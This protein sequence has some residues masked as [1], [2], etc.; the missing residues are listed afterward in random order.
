MGHIN[1]P[2]KEYHLLQTRFD[3]MVTGAPASPYLTKILE[4]LYS[5]EEANLARKIPTQ[6]TSLKKLVAKTALP[7]E[8]LKDKLTEM[9]ERG[10]LVDFEIKGKKYYTLPPVVIGFFEY[11]FMR[12]RDNLPMAE[13]A[14]L[15]ENYM[16]ENDKFARSVFQKET[17]MGR[18][19]VQEDFLDD[20]TEILDWE[21]ASALI[22]SAPTLGV[23]LCACR[24]KAEH[25]GKNCSAPM[26]V[27]LT[28]GFSAETMIRNKIARQISTEE[29]LD[30][31]KKCREAGLVQTG[32]NVKKHVSFICNCCSCC[33]G[34][35]KS[36]NTFNLKQ[37]IVSSNFIL[38]INKDKCVAC[39]RCVK[40]CPVNALQIETKDDQKKLILN[41]ELCLGCGVC[42]STCKPQ[43]LKMVARPKR[44]FTPETF[45]D[46]TVAMALE[47][48]KLADLITDQK[49][50]LSSLALGRIISLIEKLPPYKA[51]IAIKPLK[52][53][54]LNK[55]VKGIK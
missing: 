50:N 8:K 45:F 20:Q 38:E 29:G 51:L 19:L 34:M 21:K 10:V 7:E 39:G 32:D 33:C 49:D 14:N 35:L 13:L 22:K 42:C 18:A 5:P 46:K 27:C 31:L 16:D 9:T 4:I 28:L 40:A 54:F 41:E 1:N 26:E 47:R 11:V 43:A 2:D 48:G 3:K 23:S 30:I 17:Q 6:P 24:H 37:T 55:I 36:L 15:F 53:Y 44:V 52:S 12:S 25:L